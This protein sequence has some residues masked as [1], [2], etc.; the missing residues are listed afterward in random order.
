M[1]NIVTK[2]VDYS[3][4]ET[5]LEGF[6]A[7]DKTQTGPLPCVILGHAWDGQ[8]EPIH[9][10]TKE[11]AEMG[12][13]AFALDAYGK[14]KRGDVLDDNSHLMNPLMED[15]GELRLR[16]I[17]AFDAVRELEFADASRVAA[18]G[19]CFGGLC[20][21]D[22]ARSCVS[23]LSG[24]VSV[25]GMLTP[26]NIGPQEK[27]TTQ[28]LIQHGWDDPMAPPETVPAF[29]DEMTKAGAPWQLTAYGHAMHAYTYEHANKPEAGIMYNEQAAR[30]TK[31]AIQAF[32]EE[33]FV[34][35]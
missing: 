30:R 17:A 22:L 26:P 1:T 31:A 8:N 5:L 10:I 32:L 3:A 20:V 9:E 2:F 27:I 4:G 24:V 25:H 28:V 33:I 29:A 35:N 11:F 19:F 13:L 6:V 34:G 12:Y 14:G 15:R 16:L 18:V 23:G 21:L 7:Y